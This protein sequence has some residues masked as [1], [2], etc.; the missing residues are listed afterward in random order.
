MDDSFAHSLGL[1]DSQIKESKKGAKTLVLNDRSLLS[2]YDPK[3]EAKRIADAISNDTVDVIGLGLGY[4]SFALG[5]RLGTIITFEGEIERFKQHAPSDIQASI[6]SKIQVFRTNNEIDQSLASL[7]AQGHAVIVDG[8]IEAVPTLANDLRTLIKTVI[9]K[10][11]ICIIHLRTAG[12][13]IRS[14]SAVQ[15]YKRLQPHLHV[16]YITESPYGELVQLGHGIDEVLEIKKG[17]NSVSA[18][19]RPLMTFNFSGEKQAVTIADSLN[20]V[21]KIGYAQVE[22]DIALIDERNNEYAIELREI[23][24]RINRYQLYFRIFGLDYSFDVPDLNI[25]DSDNKL[26][27]DYNV[28]QFGGG[29]GLAVWDA[30]KIDPETIGQAIQQHGSIWIAVG[31]ENERHIA[32]KIGISDKHNL[33]GR[34]SF[35]S[36]ASIIKGAHLYL[37]HDSGPTH[38]AAALNIPT[39]CLFGFTSPI[40]N[41]PIGPNVTVV[42]SDIPCA[43]K[44]C[45]VACPDLTCI[46]NYEVETIIS[47]IQLSLSQ[48][49]KSKLDSASS[50]RKLGMKYFL[51]Q[52]PSEDSDPLRNL[53]DQEPSLGMPNDLALSLTREWVYTTE[54]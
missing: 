23:R 52:Q 15:A 4:I 24:N 7:T 26:P 35:T 2:A 38:L 11:S 5:S 51:P 13:V 25:P 42:Q 54:R 21:W 49:I 44:G 47:A 3:K 33:C 41:A 45:P 32:E 22:D 34:T 1:L 9:E 12:D 50:L 53:M 36:L 28:V 46:M 37:G 20:A 17:V 14:L 30:K 10:P 43:F 8:S 27:S 39:V 19:L 31:G 40:L 48:D 18:G 6:E 16:T 29:S